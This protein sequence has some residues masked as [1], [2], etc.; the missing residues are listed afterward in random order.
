MSKHS[1]HTHIHTFLFNS[2]TFSK[3]ASERVPARP[4]TSLPLDTKSNSSLSSF[5]LD[6]VLSTVFFTDAAASDSVARFDAAILTVSVTLS[7]KLYLEFTFFK[8]LTDSITVLPKPLRA[9]P[10][11]LSFFETKFANAARTRPPTGPR[12]TKPTIPP[13]TAAA[14]SILDL[15][16]GTISYFGDSSDIRN[17]ANLFE[18]LGVNETLKAEATENIAKN[19]V[20]VRIM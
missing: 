20:K 11:S 13:V 18:I 19:K 16:N 9:S 4:I 14:L 3:A 15:S 2:S 8:K 17:G 7:V 5:T 10:A 12:I 1:T 6:I